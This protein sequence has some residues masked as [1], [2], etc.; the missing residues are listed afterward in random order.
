MKR[1]ERIARYE[2]ILNRAE[3]VAWQAEEALEAYDSVQ[4]ELKEL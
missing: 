3:T 1:L 2:Q 4:A